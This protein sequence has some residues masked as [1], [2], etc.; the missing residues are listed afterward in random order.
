MSE[1]NN[2]NV[3][4]A[5]IADPHY[6]SEALGCTGEAYRR[7]ASSDQKLLAET[8]GILCSALNQIADSD[9][10][11]LLIAGDLTNDGELVS[12]REVREQLYAFQKKKPVY[13]ITATHDFCCD[14]NPRRFDGD[15]VFH[16]V[17]T[18]SPDDL[19]NFYKDFGAEKAIAECFTDNGNS[20]YVIRPHEGIS[21]FCLNDDQD[22]NGSSGYSD[23]HFSWIKEQVEKAKRRGDVVFGMQHHHLFLTELDRVINSK[24][25]VDYR[26]AQ[27]KKFAEIGLSVMFVGHS[28]MQHI[29]R[30]DSGNGKHFYEINIAS[31]SGYPAPIAY[32]TA[33]NF[34]VAVKT[35]PLESFEYNGRI[36]YNDYLR[37]HAA[38]LI[39]GVIDSAVHNDKSE[40]VTLLDSVGV[41]ANKAGKLWVF[42]K[43]ELKRLDRITVQKAARK[44]N[45]LTHGRGIDKEAAEEIGNAK[46]KTMVVDAFLAILDGS[47]TTHAPN[48]AYYKVFTEALSFPRHWVQKFLPKKKSLL[49]TLGHLENASF[50]VMTGGPLNN[51]DY[52]AEF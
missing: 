40:F 16:D 9:A 24:D 32:C 19:R 18:L 8:K 45:H 46:V 2:L 3:K 34:G 15:E 20:S 50:E 14:N 5:V 26:E 31:I 47:L 7:R 51:N 48:S 17:A 30:V 43:S 21:L 49:R 4:F 36:Y 11:F 1:K 39:L 27:A 44:I 22:G 41:S 25:A 10:E 6:Y 42:A 37:D 12:H 29:R 52:F 28:H 23:D 35:K 38:S 13:V 33:T